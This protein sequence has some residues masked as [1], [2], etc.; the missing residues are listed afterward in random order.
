MQA[1]RS[2]QCDAWPVRTRAGNEARLNLMHAR[3][4]RHTTYGAQLHLVSAHRIQPEQV[5]H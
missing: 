1:K 3:L 4:D 5:G 2:N